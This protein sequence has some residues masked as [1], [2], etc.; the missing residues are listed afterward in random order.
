MR[1]YRHIAAMLQ[2]LTATVMTPFQVQ[3]MRDTKTLILTKVQ[4]LLHYSSMLVLLLV[5]VIFN[6]PQYTDTGNP[7]EDL[8]SNHPGSLFIL[9]AIIV[10]LILKQQLK[11]KTINISVDIDTFKIA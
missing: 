8:I 10:F 7:I 9:P 3:R 11:F 5:A 4:T 6:T 1:T 2:S